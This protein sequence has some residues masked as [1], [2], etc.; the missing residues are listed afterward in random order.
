VPGLVGR[1]SDGVRSL[2]ETERPLLPDAIVTETYEDALRAFRETPAPYVTL[3]GEVLLPPGIVVL[4]PGGAGE[5]LLATRREIRELEESVGA[6]RD[7]LARSRERRGGLAVRYE[8]TSAALDGLRERQHDLDKVLVG[9]EHR[10][11]QLQQERARVGRKADVL[12]SERERLISERAT[13]G[14]KKKEMEEALESEEAR[15]TEAEVAIDA[16][17]AQ[18]SNRRSGVEDLQATAAEAQSRLAA[19]RERRDA[20]RL[21]VERLREGVSE[22]TSR[23]EA[24]HRERASLV[25][26]KEA[27]GEGIVRSRSELEASLASRVEELERGRLLEERLARSRARVLTTEAALKHRRRELQE[28]R[29]CRGGEEIALAKVESDLEHLREGFEGSHQMTLAEAAAL[30]GP[31]EMQRDDA[32][33]AEELAEL[34]RKLDAIGPVNPMADE[35]YRELESRHEF[36]TRQ[37]QDLLDSIEGTETAIGRIDRTS[38]QRFREAFDAIN[39]EFGVTFKQLFGGGGAGL[40]LVDETD[41]LESGIDII[42]QPPGKKLQNVL[43]LSGGEKAMTAI[44][45]LFAIFRYRPSPFCLLDEVDAPL[46]DANV[47]RFLS[48]LRELRGTTQFI[49]ITHNR[50]TME[51]ADQLYGVT[52]EEPGISK[53]VSVSL[54][55]SRPSLEAAVAT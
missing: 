51:M 11:S 53:L 28:I 7:E 38:R 18:L 32:E 15:K 35:E 16:L 24:H 21:D 34:K 46:D 3:D 41:I 36:V 43:L 5:G 9:A 45:L 50:K 39:Q 6:A 30:L 29:E 49:V 4:G 8:E 52:M 40:R 19:L 12:A 20:L 33:M 2:R 48:M 10:A 17:R 23:V 26:R 31:A 27:L 55:E 37:R 44:A 14:A 42:A 25:E 47:G 13:L 54:V 1:L 22:L